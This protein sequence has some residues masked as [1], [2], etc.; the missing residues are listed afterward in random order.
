M[1]RMWATQ[2]QRRRIKAKVAVHEP[3]FCLKVLSLV[4]Y[5]LC[6]ATSGWVARTP[7][8]VMAAVALGIPRGRRVVRAKTEAQIKQLALTTGGMDQTT[9]ASSGLLEMTGVLVVLSP[10][11]HRSTMVRHDPQEPLVDS[12][13]TSW[14]RGVAAQAVTKAPEEIVNGLSRMQTTPQSRRKFCQKST[15]SSS[16]LANL[17]WVELTLILG[18]AS[19]SSV[20]ACRVVFRSYEMRWQ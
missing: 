4:T 5:Q 7:G 20:C 15:S 6:P 17:R 13:I 9:R 12:S 8:R 3:R 1:G 2:L 19:F 14:R 11:A 18:F 16:S 10:A